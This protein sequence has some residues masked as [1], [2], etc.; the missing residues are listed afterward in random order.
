MGSKAFVSANF[1]NYSVH[2]S[3]DFDIFFFEYVKIPTL[4]PTPTPL[5]LG[6][7]RC[8]N[9][10]FD[11]IFLLEISCCVNNVSFI[12]KFL[13]LISI[14]LSVVLFYRATCYVKL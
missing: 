3:G 14:K 6:I 7:D 10:N 2:G 8:I 11:L 1:D 13:S 12:L 5:G 4:C 9:L